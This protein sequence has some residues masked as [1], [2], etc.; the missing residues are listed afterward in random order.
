MLRKSLTFLYSFHTY[1]KLI[2]IVERVENP[3][4][5]DPNL[6]C[7]LTEVVDGVVRKPMIVSS[8]HFA[9]LRTT[10]EEYA[11]PLAPRSSI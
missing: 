10:H 9:P 8:C 3:K 7:L 6:L 4:D 2:N 11:T 5:V 1:L